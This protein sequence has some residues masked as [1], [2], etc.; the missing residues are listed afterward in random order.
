M[1][2]KLTTGVGEAPTHRGAV[3]SGFHSRRKAFSVAGAFARRNARNVP[4][5]QLERTDEGSIRVHVSVAVV[6]IVVIALVLF[7]LVLFFIVLFSGWL[8]TSTSLVRLY[9]EPI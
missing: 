8:P 7:C 6:I 2:D 4:R 3:G 1:I 9:A 5:A